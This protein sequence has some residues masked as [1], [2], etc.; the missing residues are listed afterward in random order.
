MK[1]KTLSKTYSGFIGQLIEADMECFTIHKAYKMASSSK[2]AV[3]KMLSEMVKKGWLLR[4][5]EGL[6]YRIPQERDPDNFI[7]N[8]HITASCLVGERKFY[9][10]YYSALEIHSL[11]TQPALRERV[12]VNQ[13]IKPSLLK[14]QGVEFQFIY[15]NDKHFFGFTKTKID[16]YHRVVCSDLEKTIIDCLYKPEYANGIVEVAKA[17]YKAKDTINYDK[18]M[19]YVRRFDSQAV[20]KRFGFLVNLLEIDLPITNELLEM[21]SNAY[22]P[23]DPSMPK[24]GKMVSKWRILVNEDIDTI[25][26]A[27]H[28]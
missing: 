8:W 23:L 10:A 14:L 24:E 1:H 6:Y 15:H 13:Q 17:I 27:P 26:Q 18:F 7:P 19:S 21:R 22:T 12:V 11:I 3:K 5:K 20:I 25:I 2:E 28:T 9:I 4:L 16:K